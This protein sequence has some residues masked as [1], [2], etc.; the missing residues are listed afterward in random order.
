M[1][2]FKEILS[3]NSKNLD[4]FFNYNLPNSSRLNKKL[5]QAM[6]YSTIGSGK[7][8]RGFL[9]SE[10]G[11]LGLLCNSKKVTDDKLKEL[12]I[13]S[14]AVEAIHSYSLIHD[15]LP[16][17]DNSDFRRGKEST[18]IKFDEGTAILA[19]DALQSWAFELISNPNNISDIK[20]ISE[21]V[22]S[23]SKS[24]GFLG[25]AGGQ[26]AD[27]D[28]QVNNTSKRQI[29]WIQKKKT[30]SLI[31]CSVMIGAILGECNVEQK[32]NLLKYS[33]NLG[34]AF[35]IFDDLLD[36][37]GSE[38]KMGKPIHQDELNQTP[39]FVN[40]LGETESRKKSKLIVEKAIESLKIFGKNAKNLV[41][42]A[43]YTINRE[44]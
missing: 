36:L 19:G 10:T 29:Y 21:I 24:I 42:L 33:K 9:V 6:R 27:I 15:D 3:K 14:A 28:F 30:V 8:I 12:T 5:I 32:R 38:F 1:L 31:D 16:A 4:K 26:Q 37:K 25:M 34:L 43:K 18:H 2:H 44:F 17:M 35:Q 23:L 41:L 22:F 40:L 7:K 13:A 39:N 20:H 11:K